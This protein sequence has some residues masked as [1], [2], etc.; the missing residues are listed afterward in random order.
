ML[1]VSFLQQSIHYIVFVQD[2]WPLTSSW[3]VLYFS[4]SKSDSPGLKVKGFHP[5]AKKIY[6]CVF[7]VFWPD[8]AFC[9]DPKHFIV[10]CEQNIVKCAEKW[11]PNVG[12]IKI[13][14]VDSFLVCCLFHDIGY[15]LID[16]LLQL[17]SECCK[18]NCPKCFRNS[19]S[20]KYSKSF[21]C[22]SEFICHIMH[23]DRG[24]MT[25]FFLICCQKTIFILIISLELWISYVMSVRQDF[26]PYLW[27]RQK[28]K[29]MCVFQVSWPYLC[30]WPDSKHFIVN[31]EENLVKN[32][33]KWGK[34]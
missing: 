31:F 25:F 10:K 26:E 14:F 21:L 4:W 32:A 9:P 17:C 15:F 13:I 24:C 18:W 7:Q 3:N 34:M 16:W 8:L 20:R 12:E 29:K 23:C 33:E 11:W 5:K 27:F 2:I 6:I 19:F 28:K 22:Y 30:F 1:R